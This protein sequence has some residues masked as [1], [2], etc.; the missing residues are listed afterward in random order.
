MILGSLI[1]G[2][3]GLLCTVIGWLIWKK[4][5]MTLLHD[6]HYKYVSEGDKKPFCGAV[7]KGIVAIGVGVLVTALLFSLTQSIWSFLGLVPGF[8]IG[9]ALLFYADRKYNRS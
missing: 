8:G 6:Y 5:K 3:V 4:Q 1:L 9:F 2:L 7:G